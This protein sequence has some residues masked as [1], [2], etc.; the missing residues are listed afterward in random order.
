MAPLVSSRRRLLFGGLAA[1]ALP[2]W[3][4]R[5]VE[6]FQFAERIELAGSTLELN[7]VGL[8]AVAWLKGYAMALYMTQRTRDAAQAVALAG[9][10]RLQMRMLVDVD[11]DEF[12]KA[13]VK[14]VSRNTP[15]GEQLRLE[16]RRKRF[17]AQIQALRRLRKRDTIDLDFVPAQGLLMTVNGV[18]RGEP[19][20]GADLYAA[21]MRVFLGD[22]P[23]DPEL[24]A[25]LL[26]GPAI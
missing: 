4:D 24:K 15:P 25:G 3:A 8:R 23:A 21:L 6:G 11:A 20:A 17:A 16:E 7:G 13:F 26:G 5:E 1:V 22:H 14:G 18:P 9:P 19:I 12:V 10:K 2:A